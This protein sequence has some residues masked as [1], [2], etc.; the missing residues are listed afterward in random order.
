MRSVKVE[1]ESGGVLHSL[2]YLF[3]DQGRL[4]EAEAMYDRALEG[5]KK[6]WGREHTSTLDTVNN[7]GNLYK[8]QGR[9]QEAEAMYDRALRGYERIMGPTSISTYTPPLNTLENL[10]ILSQEQGKFDN[11]RV[12]V[13]RAVDGAEVVWGHNSERYTELYKILRSISRD[14][15]ETSEVQESIQMATNK[16]G[17]KW[18]KIRAK[19]SAILRPQ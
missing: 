18:R 10:G 1:N 12:C 6:A 7:L 13:Q 5:K 8:N 3:A 11:A 17:R 2:G 9:L 19:V 4:H 16:A 14:T 15:C